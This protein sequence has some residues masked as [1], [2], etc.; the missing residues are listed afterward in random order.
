MLCKHE[1]K[2][3]TPLFST[4]FIENSYKKRSLY[5]YAGYDGSE[6]RFDSGCVHKYPLKE[7]YNVL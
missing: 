5:Q 2:G 4:I 6:I 1:V 3:S 7:G